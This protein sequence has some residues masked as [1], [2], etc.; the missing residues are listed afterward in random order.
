M[1]KCCMAYCLL[2]STSH[3]LLILNT[4]NFAVHMA[5]KVNTSPL[6]VITKFVH[7]T[8]SDQ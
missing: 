4:F 7:M 6:S 3:C 2:I 5:P 8:S 1:K